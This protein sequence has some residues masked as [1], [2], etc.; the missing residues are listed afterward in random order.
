MR[1]ADRLVALTGGPGSVKTTL[2]ERLV[3]AGFHA[4]PEGGRAIIRDQVAIG[5]HGLPWDDAALFAEFML[6]WELRSYRWAQRLPP[7]G[8][9]FFDHA[10]PCLLG[11]WLLLGR[12]VP[13]HVEAAVA[14]FPYHQ[15][16][17]VAPPWEA[18]YCNDGERKQSFDQACKAY[19]AI[20]AGYK[21]ANAINCGYELVELPRARVDERLA[22]ILNRLCS[23]HERA[24]LSAL[25]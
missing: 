2:V 1:V 23:T 15:M 3:A 14:A 18:I 5:G 13:A 8:P 24:P 7:P 4:A 22:F 17:F 19:D 9:V 11:Y 6:Q 20:V 10:L 21:Y 16:I 12:P 25:D